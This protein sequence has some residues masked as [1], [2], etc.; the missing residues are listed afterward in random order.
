MRLWWNQWI[1]VWRWRNPL[2]THFQHPVHLIERLGRIRG[3]SVLSSEWPWDHN[4]VLLGVL[5]CDFDVVETKF[6]VVK[7][8]A[9]LFAAFSASQKSYLD[10]VAEVM[11]HVGEWPWEL[12]ICL[13]DVLK[14]DFGESDEAVFRG[15]QRPCE[16][17]IWI[18]GIKKSD[19][20]EVADVLFQIG[21]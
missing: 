7:D 2:R 11:F 1:D 15:D 20:D 10:E 13:L 4:I 5:N 6:E 19:W 16:I 3:S 12:I 17:I 14:W 18:L 8:H 21:E 9:I